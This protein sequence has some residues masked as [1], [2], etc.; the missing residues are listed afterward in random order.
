MSA[1]KRR[2]LCEP[3]S[4]NS[5]PAQWMALRFFVRANPFSGPIGMR[6]FQATILA[7]QHKPLRHLRQVGTGSDSDPRRMG[8]SPLRSAERALN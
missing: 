4:P 2:G 5:R 1:A 7:P 3:G 8:G 6:E